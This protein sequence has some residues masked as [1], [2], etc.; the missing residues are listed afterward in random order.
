MILSY[1]AHILLTLL[2]LSTLVSQCALDR[3]ILPII[4]FS[5]MLVKGATSKVVAQFAQKA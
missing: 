5:K 2:L 4:P 3:L 1:Y